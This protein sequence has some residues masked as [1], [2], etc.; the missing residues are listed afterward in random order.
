MR[1]DKQR[2]YREK[3][4]QEQEEYKRRL[5]KTLTQYNYPSDKDNAWNKHRLLPG[6]AKHL[7]NGSPVLPT[8][9]LQMGL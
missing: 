5:T 7:V 4:T 6:T 2:S 1:K 9:Q 8:A 3:Q